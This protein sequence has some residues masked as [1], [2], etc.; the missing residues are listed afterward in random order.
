[1]Q[2]F[3]VSNLMGFSVC[4]HPGNYTH[5]Q[6]SEHVTPQN[7][8]VAFVP[9]ADTPTHPQPAFLTLRLVGEVDLIKLHNLSESLFSQE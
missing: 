6:V 5:S 4:I 7:L 3:K 1:M 9:L 2:E 8:L